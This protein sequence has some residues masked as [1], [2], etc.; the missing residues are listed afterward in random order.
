MHWIALLPEDGLG[1]EREAWGWHALQFTA[2]VAWVDEAL[3]LE[4]SGS[5]RLWGG[6]AQLREKLFDSQT[7]LPPMRAVGAG[8]TSL[9]ALALMRLRARGQA[10]PDAASLP[11]AFPLDTLQAAVPHVE[12]LARMGCNTW[13]DVRALP[14]GGMARRF[15]APMLDA[16]DAAW[17]MRPERYAWIEAPESFDE[18]LE[19]PATA[20]S[21]P[22]LMWA[23]QR[24][25]S[26]LQ[27]WLASRKLGV[28]AL[29]LEWTHDLKRLNG[30]MLPPQAQLVIR[31]ARP[32]QDMAHLRRLLNEQLA[33]VVLAAPVNHLRMR[34][35]ETASWGG[36]PVSLLPEDQ[37]K[38]ERLHEF[39]ERV[40]ARLGEDAVC[41][42]QPGN[43]HRPERMQDWVAAKSP[44]ARPG[45]A[46]PATDSLFPAWLLPRPQQ[47]EVHNDTPHYG[48]PLR[49]LTRPS[50]VDT[51]WWEEGE[52][53]FRDYYV[54]HGDQ[55]GLVW[56]YKERR[57]GRWYLQ[58]FYA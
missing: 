33:Q 15:G 10:V 34:S 43:D 56:I 23:A 12:L 35:L 49:R 31:T 7:G 54:A 58:G 26:R 41:V 53:C 21:A 51:A 42:M 45:V 14:R 17:G 46:H 40:S 27:A 36:V 32:A 37:V 39:V 28:L 22:E 9:I 38:G 44:R 55:S 48:G 6:Q 50:R 24:L 4:V 20:T 3:M 5:L 29:E 47:L 25:L 13:G 8:R 16:L 11:G 19:L 18:K 30:V 1:A 2:R 52:P 57:S